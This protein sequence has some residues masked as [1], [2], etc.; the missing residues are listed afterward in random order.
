MLPLG[1]ENSKNPPNEGWKANMQEN[2][3]KSGYNM[4]QPLEAEYKHFKNKNT[5]STHQQMTETEA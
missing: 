5:V 4:L 2:G 3:E 1:R